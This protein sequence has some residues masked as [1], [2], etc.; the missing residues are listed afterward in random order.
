MNKYYI[1]ITEYQQ[2]ITKTTNQNYKIQRQESNMG[3]GVGI[4][5]W[6]GYKGGRG[7]GKK[8]RSKGEAQFGMGE[9]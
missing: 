2:H 6:G 5:V 1:N 9:G 8:T 4:G 3:L 7:H